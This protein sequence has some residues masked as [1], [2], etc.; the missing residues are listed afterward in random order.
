M[1]LGVKKK[2]TESLAMTDDKPKFNTFDFKVQFLAGRTGPYCILHK[3]PL[4]S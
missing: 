3:H 2:K 4:A 1:S